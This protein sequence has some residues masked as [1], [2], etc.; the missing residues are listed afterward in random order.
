V[1]LFYDF[2]SHGNC[3]SVSNFAEKLPEIGHHYDQRDAAINE[4]K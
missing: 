2:E 4:H 1:D 3:A